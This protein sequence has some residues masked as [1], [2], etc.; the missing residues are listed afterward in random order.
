MYIQKKKCLERLIIILYN[1]TMGGQ[2]LIETNLEDIKFL[3]F[4][5]NKIALRKNM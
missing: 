2:Q 4:C 5:L 1:K 3:S